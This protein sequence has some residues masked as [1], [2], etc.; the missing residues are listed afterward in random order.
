MVETNESPKSEPASDFPLIF[1]ISLGM[2]GVVFGG[3]T[4]WS[5]RMP[6]LL[7]LLAGAAISLIG[8]IRIASIR[9]RGDKTF[10]V[11]RECLAYLSWAGMVAGALVI[12]FYG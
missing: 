10:T 4:K 1:M 9:R 11:R 7:I 2:G 6:A 5:H 8:M 12:H 3:F